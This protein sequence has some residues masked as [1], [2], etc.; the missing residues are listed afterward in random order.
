MKKTSII[1]LIVLMFSGVCSSE[2]APIGNEGVVHFTAIYPDAESVSLA[3]EFNG[4][5]ANANP[6]LRDEKGNWII[7]IPLSVGFHEYKFVVDSQWIP[8]PNN[9]ATVVNNYGENNSTFYVNALG[10]VEL[11]AYEEGDAEGGELKIGKGKLYLAL[12]WHQHQPFYLDSEKDQLIA[13]W[14]RTHT[15]KDYYDMTAM[16]K[17]HPDIH[18]TM[19]LTPVLLHQMDEYYIKRLA[20]FYNAETNRINT[21]EFLAQWAGKTDPWIDLMFTDTEE[22]GE[23]E[24]SYLFRNEWSC[25]S[26]SHVLMSRFPDYVALAEK[27][28]SEFTV[29]DK[30]NLKSLFYLALFDPDFLNGP[31]TMESGK[32]VDLSDLVIREDGPVWRL[33][34]PFTEDD[35]NRLVAETYK[36]AEGVIAVHKDLA[37]DAETHE[38]QVEIITTP[39]FHPILPL[40]ANVRSGESES[41][42]APEGLEFSYPMDAKA[43]VRMA[44]E[45]YQK[46]FGRK[47]YGF[48]PAEG[49]VS[50]QVVDYFVE[51]DIL[52]IATGDGVLSKS[53]PKGLKADTPYRVTG[54]EGGQTA[55]I[56]RDT[57]LSDLIG[58]R[59][60][61][62]EA[63][64]A[65]Q[66]LINRIL[67]NVPEEEGA[68]VFLTV[69]LDGENAWEWYEKDVD[70][71]GFLNSFYR[72]LTQQQE[73]GKILTVTPTEYILGNAERGI[74]AHPLNALPKLERM[75]P[76][77]WIRGDY[78]TWIGEQEENEA[79]KWLVRVRNDLHEASKKMDRSYRNISTAEAYRM[80]WQSM[81]AA[82]G[83]DWFWWY[84]DDQNTGEGDTRWD[85]LYRAHLNQVYYYLNK[86]GVK[87]EAPE[88]PSLIINDG[89][90][91]NGGGAM[92]QGE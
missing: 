17:N 23:E 27:E 24:D 20:P 58:F 2:Y 12:V 73:S 53:T 4:W 47:P 86:A 19:N 67:L 81:Y 90:T 76:G 52:W 60:Q 21:T 36:V 82:E 1:L 84:G 11:R 41:D 16:V 28:R 6:M 35:A 45:A 31:V 40:I 37:Y 48:W 39:Y 10:E 55:V 34:H 85:K 80:A 89:S 44:V 56:F 9:P 46:W 50:E 32:T 57:H 68:E 70:A 66:D 22:F 18:F 49:S 3:G 83:S 5:D 43:Q 38:G 30:R 65:A 26:V 75:W 29:Q 77:S 15:T 69:L 59:Y 64:E 25:F 8:D 63:E 88:I 61:R 87:I 54:P 51:N 42:Q 91:G 14:V 71:K 92:T 33:A 7:S 62:W 78:S 79:W 74:E 72:N 13:P